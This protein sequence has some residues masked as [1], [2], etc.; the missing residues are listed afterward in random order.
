MKTL[1]NR[2][3]EAHA[4][5]FQEAQA[6]KNAVWELRLKDALKI[7]DPIVRES[8]LSDLLSEVEGDHGQ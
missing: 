7:G 1:I 3:R 5:A 2:I 6:A 4:Q 8:T